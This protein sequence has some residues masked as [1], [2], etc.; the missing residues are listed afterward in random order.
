[1]LGVF[2][3]STYEQGQL[4][5]GSGHRLLFYTDGITESR[6]PAGDEFA[7]ERLVESALNHRALPA[8]AMQAAIL[9]DVNA[10]N[11]NTYEDDATLIVAAVE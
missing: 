2:P 1:M 10:F 6:S 4:A 7:E 3:E 9:A 11:A 8:D 5:I